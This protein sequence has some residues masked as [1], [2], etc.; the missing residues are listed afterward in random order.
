MNH[1]EALKAARELISDP[2]KH[3][4]DTHARDEEGV[5]CD[6]CA[7]RAVCW[8]AEGAIA[9]VLGGWSS[10]GPVVNLIEKAARET[11]EGENHIV[12]NDFKGHADILSV[13]DV[14][15]KAE[16]GAA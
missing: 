12:V 8:C 2:K 5:P 11:F 7:S 13:F 14:A 16:E 15:I 9:K 6:P 1:L 4:K 3:T 10:H